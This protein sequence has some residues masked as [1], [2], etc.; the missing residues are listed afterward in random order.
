M[1]LDLW[2]L[3][4]QAINALILIW[5]LKRF[6]FSPVVRIIAERRA[7]ADDLMAEAEAARAGALAELAKAKAEAEAQAARRADALHAAEA[8][9]A[10]RREALVTEARARAGEI[11]AAATAEIARASAA[12]QAAAAER[13]ATLAV[14]IAAKLFT[15]LPSEAQVAGFVD[16]FAEALAKM[17][18]EA[19][20]GIAPPGAP[21]RL[22]APR[23]LTPDET[24]ACRAALARVLGR[25]VEIEV[26]PDPAVIAGLEAEG[27]LGSVRN[28]FRA[29]LA[30]LSKAL[31]RHDQATA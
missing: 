28:S 16:G 31:T 12:A 20:D 5:L 18:P 1:H 19:R 22:R 29:D 17:Q 11:T 2:T 23:A 21:L 27:P 6:L 4:L 13:A 10:K 26:R 14:D 7:A 9:A 30:T 24:T 25:E 15:R 8:E 3:A